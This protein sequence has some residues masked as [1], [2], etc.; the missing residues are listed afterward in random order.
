MKCKQRLCSRTKNL[1]ESGFCSICEDVM[2]EC[3][4][5]YKA[6]EKK[7]LFPRVHLDI[8]LLTETHKKLANGC[9]VEPHIVNI[10]LL[11]GIQNILSQNEE[12][13]DALN[14]VKVLEIENTETKL[15]L[16][17]IETWLLKVNDKVEH[18][19]IR[20]GTHGNL[21]DSEQLEND[22][23]TL[24][25]DFTALKETVALTTTSKPIGHSK[26]KSC[27]ECGEMFLEN[28]ELENHMVIFH[29]LE[30]SNKCEICGKT[31]YLKWRLT[32]HTSIHAEH[33]KPC[34]YFQS[35]M[36]CP[37]AEIG[38]K[39]EHRKADIED[40][41]SEIEEDQ[42]QKDEELENTFCFFCDIMFGTQSELITHMG[43]THLDQFQHIQQANS[44]ITF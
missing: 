31:F 16:E 21:K 18:A 37:F 1:K 6:A 13:D 14:R 39:F 2:E 5:M 32:K 27:N 25:N 22:M 23:E 44:L 7:K 35:G 28:Y 19:G 24:R 9:P 34:K 12:L 17:S 29:K 11:G 41:E 3:K 43:D 20:T 40:V 30:K 33:P 38:C 4:Q 10:L 42:S 36:T 15:R 8:K 26:S